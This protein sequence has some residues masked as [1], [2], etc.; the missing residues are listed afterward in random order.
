M[1]K[2]RAGHARTTTTVYSPRLSYP[3][4][5]GHFSQNELPVDSLKLGLIGLPEA[6]GRLIATLFRLYRV[7]PSFIWTLKFE[8]PYDALL[9]DASAHPDEVSAQCGSHTRVMRLSSPGTQV[10][11]QLS[12]PIRSD[13]LM[14]WLNSIEVGILHGGHDA[15]SSTAGISRFDGSRFDGSSQMAHL[16]PAALGGA[17]AN[18]PR[19]AQAAQGLVMYKLRRWPSAAILEKNVSLIRIA[20]L[21]TRKAMT[22]KELASLSHVNE[23]LCEAFLKRLDQNGLLLIERQTMV[24]PAL[25]PN[26]A[27]SQD[28]DLKKNKGTGALGIIRSI[29][30]RFGLL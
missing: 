11:G 1:H 16:S 4:A 20:T 17:Q 19:A 9:L 21:L 23:I 24:D 8:P 7:E 15:F 30:R 10:Q 2:W 29:R 13:L 12:R 25:E 26:G 14:A 22:L 6:E 28:Q 18:P 5:A 27:T 3:A